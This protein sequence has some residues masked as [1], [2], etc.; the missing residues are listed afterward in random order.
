MGS[1]LI[2]ILIKKQE[3]KL[4]R[5]LTNDE[6]MTLTVAIVGPMCQGEYPANA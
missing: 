3:A 1:T 6:V 2:E 5:K 4:G